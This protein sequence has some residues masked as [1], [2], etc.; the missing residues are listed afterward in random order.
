M[1]GIAFSN[2]P[3]LRFFM[4]FVPVMGLDASRISIIGLAL[5]LHAYDFVWHQMLSALWATPFE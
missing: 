3:W 2:K 5:N 1:F 4:L